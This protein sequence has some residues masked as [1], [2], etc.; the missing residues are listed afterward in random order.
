MERGPAGNTALTAAFSIAQELPEDKII[1]VQESEYT[2][3][4]K[5]HQAQLS[6][7]K[8]NGIDILFGDPK[9]EIPGT[10]IILPENLSLI[11]TKDLDL[12]KI[13]TSLIRNYVKDY[14]KITNIDLNF[15]KDETNTSLKEVKAILREL[16]VEWE[17][18]NG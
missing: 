12:R 1:V 16:K 3:A 13:R 14:S 17:E 4:G 9:S 10:N 18:E 15:L 5:H 7:A 11:Q 8:E 2:G 6:F